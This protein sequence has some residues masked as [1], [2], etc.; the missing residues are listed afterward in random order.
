M[1]EPEITAAPEER[2]TPVAE[3]APRLHVLFK[4]A[5]ADYVVSA[6]DVL[7]MESFTGATRVPGT[8]SFVRGLVQIRGRVVPVVDLRERFGL[9]PA[10]PTLDS[11]IIVLAQGDRVVGLLVDSA[12]EVVQIA[13]GDLKAPPDVLMGESES[14]VKSVARVG[15]RLLMLLD[16]HRV[17]GEE[18]IHGK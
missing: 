15:N 7:Q 1:I 6:V 9:E 12:R 16:V 3:T 11:R 4:V 5:D 14:F 17:I 10:P 8:P 13:P 2:T 18:Q